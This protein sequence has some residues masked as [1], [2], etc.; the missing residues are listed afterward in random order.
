M[1]IL[2]ISVGCGNKEE[3]Y[4][5]IQVYKI[6]GTAKVERQGSSMEAYENMQLQSGDIVETVTDSYLQ[7]KL[8]GFLSVA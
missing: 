4:R 5:Q 8:D 1:F 6:D 3:D 2:M 7:L